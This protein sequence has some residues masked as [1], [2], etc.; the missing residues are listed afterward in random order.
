M[1][2]TGKAATA[3]LQQSGQGT[4]Q[5]LRISSCISSSWGT[6]GTPNTPLGLAM[7]KK[8]QTSNKKVSLVIVMEQV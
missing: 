1:E 3:A 4:H 2:T 8:L 7:A 6:Y 5:V